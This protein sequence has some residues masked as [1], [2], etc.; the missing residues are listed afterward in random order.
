MPY[1]IAQR[2]MKSRENFYESHGKLNAEWI[3]DLR[4]GTFTHIVEVKKVFLVAMKEIEDNKVY[5]S[6]FINGVFKSMTVLG[7]AKIVKVK[8]I[9]NDTTS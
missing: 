9:N 5:T 1:A 3:P 2:I 7:L 4:Y 6:K 8:E